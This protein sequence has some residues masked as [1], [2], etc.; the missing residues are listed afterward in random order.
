MLIGNE[1]VGNTPFT[2]HEK[3]I[4]HCPTFGGGYLVVYCKQ[5]V[6]GDF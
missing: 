4:L 5:S 1:A 6:Q 2:R 3:Y